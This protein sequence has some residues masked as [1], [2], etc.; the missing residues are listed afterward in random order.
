[1]VHKHDTREEVNSL[2]DFKGFREESLADDYWK[3][4][5]WGEVMGIWIDSSLKT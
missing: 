3:E 4:R 2:V 1:M 5:G